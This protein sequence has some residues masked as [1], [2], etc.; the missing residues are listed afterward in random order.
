MSGGYSHI[1]IYCLVSSPF[2]LF[3][4]SCLIFTLPDNIPTTTMYSRTLATMLAL[5]HT[6]LGMPAPVLERSVMPVATWCIQQPT[7]HMYLCPPSVIID[8]SP[9]NVLAPVYA[10]DPS[11][12]TSGLPD[13]LSP[14]KNDSCI[15]AD[16]LDRI[17]DLMAN[18]FRE[19]YTVYR[20]LCCE[21]D[22]STT[23]RLRL[24]AGS[25]PVFAPDESNC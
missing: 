7:K 14:Y 17:G 13:F 22:S 4:S 1:R 23:V 21:Q 11:F 18:M 24:I 10:A 25:T 5:T 16:H 8:S 2:L 20:P 3:N 6:A 19:E 9:T 15:G 12:N